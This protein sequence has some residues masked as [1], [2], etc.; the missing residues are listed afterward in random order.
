M[1]IHMQQFKIMP[2]VS[3][4]VISECAYN[5]NNACHAIAITIGDG[6]RPM[7][8][9]YFKS[10]TRGGI[11]D[12]A[13]VGACKVSTCSHNMDFECCATNIRIGNENNQ[14]KCQTFTM[15]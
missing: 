5:S 9:T 2:A 14:G 7:C 4:C 1:E 8:D 15:A 6:N 13:G 3:E 12:T 11:K 10:K